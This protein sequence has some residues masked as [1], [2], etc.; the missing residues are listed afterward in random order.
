M[1]ARKTKVPSNGRKVWS[2]M[3]MATSWT[4]LAVKPEERYYTDN[5]GI[6]GKVKTM[7]LAPEKIP[8]RNS[9]GNNP[10]SSRDD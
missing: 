1:K 4:N 10:E 9:P 3:A 6:D 8:I 7:G 5:D 2:V